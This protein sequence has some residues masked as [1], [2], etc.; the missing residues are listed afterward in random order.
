MT[1]HHWKCFCG[2][3]IRGLKPE[4]CPV[5]GC[6]QTFSGTTAGDRH[7]VGPYGGKRRCLSA[8]EMDAGTTLERNA[9]GHWRLAMSETCRVGTIRPRSAAA[10]TLTSAVAQRSDD[11]STQTVSV[12]A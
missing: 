6:H 7:R 1:R 5:A 11:V 3:L 9:R 2:E 8:S 12:A 4:H 10:G